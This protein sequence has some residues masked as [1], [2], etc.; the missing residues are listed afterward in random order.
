MPLLMKK[1][2]WVL[3]LFILIA[4]NRTSS[5]EGHEHEGEMHQDELVNE[6]TLDSIQMKSIQLQLDT[7]RH[8]NLTSTLKSNGFLKVPN[9]NKATISSPFPG[10]IKSLLVNPGSKIA[11]GQTIAIV[12]NPQFI[13]IQEEYLS[14][15][16]KIMLA[17]TEV[18]RQQELSGG[19]AG[20]LK[21]LQA[22][23]AELQS[24]EIRQASLKQQLQLMGINASNLSSGHLVSQIAIPSPLSGSV[25]NVLVNIGASVDVSIPIAEVVDNSSLHLDLYVFEKDLPFLKKGQVINFILTNLPDKNYTAEIF[26]VGTLF[27]N[28][29]KA[30]AVHA[31]VKGNKQDLIEGMSV[32]ALINV[33]NKF[34]AALPNE[35]FVNDQGRDYV[36]ILT[37]PHDVEAPHEHAE[38]KAHELEGHDHAQTEPTAE[39]IVFKRIL[40]KKGVSE[41]GYTQLIAL[42][43]VPADAQYVVK[44]AFFL[45]S[46]M[47]NAGE[48]HEH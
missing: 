18:K 39:A 43:E 47:T 14:L 44:G 35:A 38:D 34:V 32:T 28:E 30:V 41:L 15:G 7:I 3:F 33:D 5:E 23:E 12:S 2:G 11:R 24:L 25:G 27:E 46:K 9:Q 17:G 37:G 19:N 48:A 36:F 26:S 45:L 22:A 20:A 16:P 4:C 29:N 13:S 31:I 6:V 8:K 42:E 40:V 10:I 21:T 1:G